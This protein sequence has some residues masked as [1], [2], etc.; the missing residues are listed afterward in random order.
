MSLL[1]RFIRVAAYFSILPSSILLNGCT[2]I[3][4]NFNYLNY[5]NWW[6]FVLF[7]F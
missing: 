7:Y 2:T 5:L 3:Y 4:L 6:S 1:L